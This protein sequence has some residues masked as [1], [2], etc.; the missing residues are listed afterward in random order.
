M[1]SYQGMVKAGAGSVRGKDVG[2]MWGPQ[3][4]TRVSRCLPIMIRIKVWFFKV[5]GLALSMALLR[6]KG[7]NIF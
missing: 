2:T 6:G 1:V 7:L 5:H 4:S 3:I